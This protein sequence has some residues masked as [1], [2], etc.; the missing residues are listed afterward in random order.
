MG[1]HEAEPTNKGRRRAGTILPVVMA[2]VLVLGAVAIA[3]NAVA[4][5][6]NAVAVGA[7]DLNLGD[8]CAESSVTGNALIAISRQGSATSTNAF[9]NSAS[10]TVSVTGTSSTS[11]AA[12]LSNN[13]FS[14]PSDWAVPDNGRISAQSASSE[15]TFTAGSTLGAFIGTVSYAAAGLNTSG[16]PISRPA[17]LTVNANVIA[18]APA[19]TT[20]PVI[21]VDVNG[22]LGDNGWYVSD[23]T[24]DWSVVEDESPGSLVKTGCVDQSITSDQLATTYSCSASSDGGSSG[25]V[26]VTIRR[27]ATA[28]GLAPSVS[29]NP[30]LLGGSATATANASDS[31]SGLALESCDS[32]DT[33]SVGAKTVECTA[34]DNA[35]NTSMTSASY[36]VIYD[37]AG[38]FR[39]VDDLPTVNRVKAGSAVPVKFS[40]AG[41]QGLG[42]FYAGYPKSVAA[43]CIATA[44]TDAIEETVTA[45]G[46]SLS[47]DA[48]SDQYVYVWKTDKGW[49]NTCRQ[50]QVKLADGTMHIAMFNFTK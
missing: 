34:T 48:T 4:D 26:S 32:V 43:S 33:S 36:T 37:F 14:L 30:V 25:P 31:T 35:G 8:V 44:L 17:L 12:N 27:D 10:I 3:D 19:D 24:V 29:P 28:P 42:I 15:V 46:S 6:D 49:A 2:F 50:L 45:G 9:A 23:V 38:F 39:P 40:L 13:P 16:S 47:Y 1:R 7:N 21:N 41:D 5:G 18:C 22:T 20:A 11:L